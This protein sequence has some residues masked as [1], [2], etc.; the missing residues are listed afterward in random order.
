MKKLGFAL[1]VAGMVGAC[2]AGAAAAETSG[3]I[4]VS[5]DGDRQIYS[6]DPIQM[7]GS[8]LVPMR[9]I[10]ESLGAELHYDAKTRVITALKGDTRI[11][12]QVG[13]HVAQVNGK[14]VNLHQPAIVI[15]GSTLVPV[16]FVSEAL[17]AE[18][19]W[20][21]QANAV[22][23]VSWKPSPENMQM[24][25]ILIAKYGAS[26]EPLTQ[27][28]KDRLLRLAELQDMQ[29]LVDLLIQNGAK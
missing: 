19:K 28:Q 20:V 7:D 2:F 26:L 5:I 23:V 16:R 17:G 13:G 3:P 4:R 24:L 8:V 29:P 6:V 11:V 22:S 15:R 27:A 25:Q 9:A 1:L 10:F 21:P 18:V 14:E 12:L